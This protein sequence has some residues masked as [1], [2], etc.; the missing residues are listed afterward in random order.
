M[1]S[2]WIGWV[3]AGAAPEA[4]DIT[5]L[6]A[7]NIL[8]AL[9]VDENAGVWLFSNVPPNRTLA[10]I[11]QLDDQSTP[12]LD[13]DQWER[14]LPGDGLA[15]VV[16]FDRKPGGDLWFAT[17]ER[18]PLHTQPL[19]EGHL[20]QRRAGTLI[21]YHLPGL[22][23]GFTDYR[24]LQI[25]DSQHVLL[26]YA[27]TFVAPLW[28]NTVAR[29]DNGGTPDDPGDDQWQQY[30]VESD[31]PFVTAALDTL[32]RMWY[33]DQ[34]GI[35]RYENGAW[36]QISPLVAACR[37]VPAAG[38]AMMV[39]KGAPGCGNVDNTVHLIQAND[40]GRDEVLTDVV[41]SDFSLV[42]STTLHNAQ[43]AVAPDGAIWFLTRGDDGYLQ[44]HRYDGSQERLY[45]TPL[46]M[47]GVVTTLDV[48]ANNHVWVAADDYLWRLS[49][50][51]QPDFV[52]R[53]QPSSQ[54]MAPGGLAFSTITAIG[55]GGLAGNVTL[56][57]Q[58]L[59]SGLSAAF[60][61]NPLPLNHTSQLTFS[62]DA[63]LAEGVY[64]GQVVAQTDS[65]SHTASLSITVAAGVQQMHLPLVAK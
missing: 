15:S 64:S 38:G 36:R 55:R 12:W 2:N 45:A 60:S 48:D 16:V 10:G 42:Q 43:W 23:T 52:L 21:T 58:G 26:A 32:Q 8:G 24:V 57:I 56:A 59:P 39:L 35:Y 27:H 40:E 37:L 6:P 49:D 1:G 30:T 28:Q 14:T 44:L 47:S 18:T 5:T 54:L 20:F 9:R 46:H 62:A 17:Y 41:K 4:T 11:Q 13:D 63:A 51:S 65:L 25:I 22:S 3:R 34:T 50:R 33:A 19:V 61:P 7:G 29:F 31:H 53:V